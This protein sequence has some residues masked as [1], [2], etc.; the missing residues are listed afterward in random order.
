MARLEGIP[1]K[2]PKFGGH[3]LRIAVHQSVCYAREGSVCEP[4]V[5]LPSLPGSAVGQPGLHIEE[6]LIYGMFEGHL[7]LRHPYLSSGPQESGPSLEY[8]VDLAPLVLQHPVAFLAED[9]LD[10]SVYCCHTTAV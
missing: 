4:V 10:E 3:L 9:A 7:I 5:D 2:L 6:S 1:V 8:R